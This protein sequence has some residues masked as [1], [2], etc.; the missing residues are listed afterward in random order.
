MALPYDRGDIRK[1]K[2][3][4]GWKGRCPRTAPQPARPATEHRPVRGPGNIRRVQKRYGVVVCS[5]EASFSS[6]TANI[7][8]FCS[9]LSLPINLTIGFF[10][11]TMAWTGTFGF[12]LSFNDGLVMRYRAV[13]RTAIEDHTVNGTLKQAAVERFFRFAFR[14]E[15]LMPNLHAVGKFPGRASGNCQSAGRSRGANV[16]GSCSQ[17]WPMRFASGDMRVKNSSVKSRS[18][19]RRPGGKW[20]LET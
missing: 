6:Q 1:E 18:C 11:V 10:A 13:H 7:A 3:V 14:K 17:Y 8:W 2:I 16:A 15:V 19:A 20:W 9:M 4:V 5:H 12:T